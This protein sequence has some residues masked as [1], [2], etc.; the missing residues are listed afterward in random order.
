VH[1]CNSCNVILCFVACMFHVSLFIVVKF[2]CE[3]LRKICLL[4]DDARLVGG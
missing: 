1:V 3:N 2:V 4:I